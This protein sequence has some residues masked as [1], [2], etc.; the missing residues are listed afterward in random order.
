MPDL[1]EATA[2]ELARVFAPLGVAL[3]SEQEW[4]KLA[5]GELETASA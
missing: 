5:R 2:V 1:I 4:V 3:E